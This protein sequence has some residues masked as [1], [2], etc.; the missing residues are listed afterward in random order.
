MRRGLSPDDLG[1]LFEL[2]LAVVLSLAKRD[3]SYRPRDPWTV[4]RRL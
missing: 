1:D 3:G 2:P 4:R